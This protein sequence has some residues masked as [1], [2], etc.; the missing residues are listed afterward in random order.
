MVNS[1]HLNTQNLTN[2]MFRQ[3][4]RNNAIKYITATDPSL[5]LSSVVRS[6]NPEILFALPVASREAVHFLHW[7]KVSFIFSNPV[8][9]TEY[10]WI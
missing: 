2:L 5:H 9:R 10:N 1:D 3:I 4:G 6:L 8:Q 7:L